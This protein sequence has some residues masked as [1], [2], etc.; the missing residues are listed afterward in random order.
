MKP[1]VALFF[2]TLCLAACGGKT[3][4]AN[5]SN[6][7]KTEVDKAFDELHECTDKASQEY[8]KQYG[9][10]PSYTSMEQA[11]EFSKNYN[12]FINSK[13]RVQNDKV[14]ELLQKYPDERP[15]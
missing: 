4:T 11:E 13:C 9:K 6:Q 10:I 8:E 1:L 3:E 7:P 5:D 14:E 15:D 12:E 2:T